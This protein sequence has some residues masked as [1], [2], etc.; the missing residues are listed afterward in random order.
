[1]N[2]VRVEQGDTQFDL[3]FIVARYLVDTCAKAL[4][5]IIHDFIKGSTILNLLHSVVGFLT[6][7]GQTE[8]PQMYLSFVETH[9]EHEQKSYL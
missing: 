2:M 5:N 6:C 9:A 1:M 3:V 4:S 7:S 8:A